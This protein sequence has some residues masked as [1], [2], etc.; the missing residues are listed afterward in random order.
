MPNGFVIPRDLAAC[1][2][3]LA[4]QRLTIASHETMIATHMTAIAMHETAIKSDRLT[5][6][7]QELTI[8]SLGERIAAVQQENAEQKLEIAELFRRMFAQ[9]SERYLDNPDQLR[10][11]FPQIPEAAAAAESLAEAL[12]QAANELALSAANQIVVPEHTR[13]K[14]RPR[15]PRREQLPEHLPRYEVEAPVAEDVKTCLTRV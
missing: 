6:T 1:Q 8:A 5:I 7:T 13:L 10:L 3:L 2:A 4:E 11:D 15:A 9:R 14:H 12:Q